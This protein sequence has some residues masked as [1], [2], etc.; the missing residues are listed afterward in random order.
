MQWMLRRYPAVAR[1]M[2]ERHTVYNSQMDAIDRQEA[3]GTIFVIRPPQALGIQRTETRPEE[4]ERVYQTGRREAEA[5]LQAMKDYLAG[6][7]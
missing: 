3:D 5:R 6:Q 1:A 2:A 4:L 7:A